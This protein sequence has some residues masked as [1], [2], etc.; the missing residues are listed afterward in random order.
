MAELIELL[1]ERVKQFNM[2]VNTQLSA[3]DQEYAY[4]QHFILQVII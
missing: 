3:M 1:K 2:H 4:K